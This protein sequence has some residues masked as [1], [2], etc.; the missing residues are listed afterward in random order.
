MTRFVYGKSFFSWD[1]M[2]QYDIPAMM[3]K[4]LEV[5]GQEKIFY[6]GH[7]M[8]T[9]GY[10]FTIFIVSAKDLKCLDTRGQFRDHFMNSFFT[11][12]ILLALLAQGSDCKAKKLGVTS[13][14]KLVQLGA[15]L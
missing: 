10:L 13:R 6:I 15:A 14:V 11:S 5:T 3:T 9:T 12:I 4:V 2:G 8:G 7:S 1:Q